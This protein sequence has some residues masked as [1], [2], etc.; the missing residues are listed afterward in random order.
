LKSS[1]LPMCFGLLCCVNVPVAM[2]GQSFFLPR[3]L[4]V[5]LR[6]F[7]R[8]AGFQGCQVAS[9]LYLPRLVSTRVP[10]AL[11]NYY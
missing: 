5:S 1:T 9:S 2:A 3:L 11:E 10:I 8:R 7:S 6:F 4:Q